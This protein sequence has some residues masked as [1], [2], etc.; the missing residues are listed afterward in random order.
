MIRLARL[1]VLAPRVT[2]TKFNGHTLAHEVV[3][4][5][6]ETAPASAHWAEKAR[7]WFC[8]AHGSWFWMVIAVCGGRKIETRK[9]ISAKG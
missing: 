9:S 3:L 6:E 1:I 2:V 5:E 8:S 7:K 4:L